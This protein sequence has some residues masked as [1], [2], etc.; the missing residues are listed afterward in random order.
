MGSIST[1][2][3]ARR[4]DLKINKLG[5]CLKNT[6]LST[7]H[8]C[9]RFYQGRKPLAHRSRGHLLRSVVQCF[10]FSFYCN[11]KFSGALRAPKNTSRNQ[12]FSHCFSRFETILFSRSFGPQHFQNNF[13]FFLKIKK[14]WWFRFSTENCNV[15]AR[16]S[17]NT[18]VVIIFYR[19]L[20]SVCA[21]TVIIIGQGPVT[22]AEPVLFF[23]SLA[24]NFT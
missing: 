19:L 2:R 1:T 18:A 7:R 20:C 13:I 15:N 12:E 11:V 17:K 6:L 3:E 22:R 16:V 10:S 5:F 14:H 4:E 23:T 24:W 9:M 8:H 21:R